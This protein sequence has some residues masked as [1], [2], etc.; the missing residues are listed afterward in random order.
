MLVVYYKI[1]NIEIVRNLMLT[2]QHEPGQCDLYLAKC[3]PLIDPS[4]VRGGKAR[5]E[6]R[7]NLTGDWAS[8]VIVVRA[9]W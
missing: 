1:R 2:K 8:S 9:S 4:S 5:C 7:F 3:R 6:G